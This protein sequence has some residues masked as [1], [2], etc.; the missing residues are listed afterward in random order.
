MQKL[1]KFLSARVFLHAIWGKTGRLHLLKKPKLPYCQ[2]MLILWLRVML[3]Y[4]FQAGQSRDLKNRPPLTRHHLA[5]LACA[6]FT[7]GTP[8]DWST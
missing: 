2:I 8:P 6:V 3:N 5:E 1:K 4:N 7:S